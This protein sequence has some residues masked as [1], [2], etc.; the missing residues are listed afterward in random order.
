M[1]E[2]LDDNIAI[3]CENVLF[4]EQATR[5][6]L[7]AQSERVMI[8]LDQLSL[9]KLVELQSFVTPDRLLFLH[10]LIAI[11]FNL[12]FRKK[13]L[14]SADS[15]AAQQ[16][17]ATQQSILDLHRSFMKDRS[18][19]AIPFVDTMHPG[20]FQGVIQELRDYIRI[21]TQLRGTEN[22]TFD[23]MSELTPDEC[24]TIAQPDFSPI[25]DPDSTKTS[26]G[27]AVSLNFMDALE[28]QRDE[29]IQ[30]YDAALRELGQTML[31]DLYVGWKP[32]VDN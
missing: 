7:H 26:V 13:A 24:I 11:D 12:L 29:D 16:I 28:L 17:D 6:Q 21:Q 27:L 4:T 10:S 14:T 25:L 22:T 19:P 8:Q 9:E 30:R 5:Q 2:H 20:E 15:E 1:A 3:V 32:G 18:V 31:A 23:V